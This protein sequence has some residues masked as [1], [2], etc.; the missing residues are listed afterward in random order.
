MCLKNIYYVVQWT[1]NI[2]LLAQEIGSNWHLCTSFEFLVIIF[3]QTVGVLQR[4]MKIDN[5]A[6]GYTFEELSEMSRGS[7]SRSVPMVLG[8]LEFTQSGNFDLGW[9]E[10]FGTNPFHMN[11]HHFFLLFS[12]IQRFL[13]S[14]DRGRKCSSPSGST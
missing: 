10:V 3:F 7:P 13:C 5:R 4:H 1:K 6:K 14:D 2:N 11:Y 8:S 12:C 9:L